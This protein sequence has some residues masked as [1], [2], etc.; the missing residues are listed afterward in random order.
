MILCPSGSGLPTLFP[1]I[2]SPPASGLV[3]RLATLSP[4][5][6]RKLEEVTASD[7]AVPAKKR[8]REELDIYVHIECGIPV[9]GILSDALIWSRFNADSLFL[10]TESDPAQGRRMQLSVPFFGSH[11]PTDVFRAAG[12]LERRLLFK[13]SQLAELFGCSKNMIA[14]YLSR[15]RHTTDGIYQAFNISF[16]HYSRKDIRP[17]GYYISEQ[18]CRDFERYWRSRFRGHRDASTVTHFVQ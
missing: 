14:M 12:D 9:D 7:E 3:S 1:V 2:L 17:L 6:K 15:R 5:G 4:A 10:D 11:N 16:K 18:V 8:R 13:A